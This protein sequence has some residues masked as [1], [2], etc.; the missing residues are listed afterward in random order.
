MA[1]NVKF[2]DLEM[3]MM[4]AKKENPETVAIQ[5]EDSGFAAS[6][7]FLDVESRECKITLH[8]SSIQTKPDLIKKMK[9]KTRVDKN[10]KK[11]E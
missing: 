6:F 9:L 1:I 5:I 7:S 3:M 4:Y 8:E 11:T 2:E 10:D